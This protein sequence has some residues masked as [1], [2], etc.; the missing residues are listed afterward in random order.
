MRLRGA[1]KVISHYRVNLSPTVYFFLFFFK[2][3]MVI[4]IEE[5]FYMSSWKNSQTAASVLALRCQSKCFAL[6][7][8]MSKVPLAENLQTQLKK[9]ILFRV[10]M[11]F[12]NTIFTGFNRAQI[13]ETMP[14]LITYS[15]MQSIILSS[16][17]NS[18]GFSLRF[19]F[20][21]CVPCLS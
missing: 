8:R 11:S 18:K 20:F 6:E 15:F 17:H 3:A 4:G 1:P 2:S 19:S 13:T 21:L 14:L 7:C 9:M 5:L 10:Q 16:L 12:R